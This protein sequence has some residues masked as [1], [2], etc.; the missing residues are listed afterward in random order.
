MPPPP[1]RVDRG[2]CSACVNR[3]LGSIDFC[4][5]S[6]Q[7]LCQVQKTQAT[8]CVWGAGRHAAPQFEPTDA[9]CH[10]VARPV[11]DRVARLGL[12]APG[13]GWKDSLKA[14]RCPPGAAGIDVI[15]PVRAQAG[16]RRAGSGRDPGP[17]PGAVV[18]R[19]VRHARAQG[20]SRSVRR[21][22]W[23][24][25]PTRLRPRAGSAA[26]FW[27]RMSVLRTDPDR[28]A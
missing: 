14:P 13:P 22:I 10:G 20:T 25:N 17:D 24:L 3:L 5:H 2:Y 9:A 26:C 28:P 21:W 18:A 16:P 6:D 23:V 7:S 4:L 1:V 8:I 27:A 19:A 12:R 15:G 11:P